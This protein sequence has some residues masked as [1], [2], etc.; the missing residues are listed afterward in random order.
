MSK[1]KSPELFIVIGPQHFEVVGVKSSTKK[2]VV[3]ENGIRFNPKNKVALNSKF[4]VIDYSEEEAYYY[5]SIRSIPRMI[6]S[7]E[8][9]F[10]HSREED[11]KQ[12]ITKLYKKLSR[13][14]NKIS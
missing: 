12:E 6:K 8:K 4:K 13:I 5:E 2:E 3:L 10:Q 14:N 11:N 1:S 9:H 7:I